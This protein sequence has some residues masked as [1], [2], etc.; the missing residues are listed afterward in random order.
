MVKKLAK[1]P[2]AYQPGTQWEY[3]HSTDVLGKVIEV[4]SG[5]TL[6]RFIEARILRPLRMESSG[7]YVKPEKL[8]RVAESMKDPKTGKAYPFI[9]DVTKPPKF[10]SGARG[11]V[12]ST[13]DYA[14]F[15]QMLLNRGQLDGVRILSPKT[16]AY[17][18]S[19]HLGTAIPTGWLGPGVSFGL[20]FAVRMQ[21]GIS[22]L[23]GTAGEYNWAG[24][25]G[26]YFWVDPKE[27]LVAVFMIQD[28]V[29]GPVFYY[30]PIV[31]SLV[32]QAIID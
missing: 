28:W 17:M 26:T 27:E 16:V 22:S 5:M 7:F 24:I 13:M 30:F 6:D 18:T 9:L 19:D 23:I 25:A 8:N 31:R 11:M 32:Y 4:V 15:A 14:R 3:S 12:A 1:I 29:R 10:L 20:G 2:L 21:N